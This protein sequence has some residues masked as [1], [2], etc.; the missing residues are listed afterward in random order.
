M[1][2]LNEI[3]VIKKKID[4]EEFVYSLNVMIHQQIQVLE[5]L[6]ENNVEYVKSPLEY[7]LVAGLIE[8][9][10][11]HYTLIYD[12]RVSSISQ[13]NDDGFNPIPLFGKD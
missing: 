10:K 5:R 11:A 3:E 12:P 8:Q 7:N 13:V 9:I 4:K 1:K 2:K 6:F